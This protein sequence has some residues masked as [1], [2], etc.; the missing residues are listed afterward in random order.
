MPDKSYE[1]HGVRI[2]K[3]GSEGAQPRNE[4]DAADLINVAWEHRA[5]LIVLPVER[6]GDDFFQL[7]TRIAGE[8]IQKF[9]NYRLRVAIVGDISRYVAESSPLRDFVYESNRGDQVWFVATIEELG[10]RLEQAQP[11]GA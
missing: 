9:V 4:R 7:K 1:L 6:L 3:C 8:I 5:Q 2:F 11:R 10:Q